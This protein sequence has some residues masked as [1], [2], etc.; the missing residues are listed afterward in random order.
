[1]LTRMKV[2]AVLTQA[3]GAWLAECEEVDRAGEGR[4]PDEALAS[5]RDALKDYFNE[6]QAV[7]PPPDGERAPP[8]SIE[9]VVIDDPRSPGESP[10]R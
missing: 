2:T 1:M 7:A 8:E 5:L 9:I 6:T 4:T 10:A 3:D